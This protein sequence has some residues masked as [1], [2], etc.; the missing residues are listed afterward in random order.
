MSI[1]IYAVCKKIK[2]NL[3]QQ[4]KHSPNSQ[5]NSRLGNPGYVNGG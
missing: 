4:F 5:E 2:T 3:G 1:I